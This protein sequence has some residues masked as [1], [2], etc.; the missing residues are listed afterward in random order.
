ME[1]H[2]HAVFLVVM[3]F[4]QRHVNTILC[5]PQSIKSFNTTKQLPSFW[6]GNWLITS[7][8]RPLQFSIYCKMLAKCFKLFCCLQCLWFVL[9]P[10]GVTPFICAS[11]SDIPGLRKSYKLNFMTFGRVNQIL[12]ICTEG[13]SS[14]T[15]R[16]NYICSSCLVAAQQHNDH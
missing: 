6:G 9:T 5:L 14:S 10:C 13:D 4:I 15:S 8:V 16:V 3:K 11:M 2:G 1:I 12:E 7:Q